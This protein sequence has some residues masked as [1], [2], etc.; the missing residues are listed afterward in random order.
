RVTMC[1]FLLPKA[2]PTHQWSCRC[3][4]HPCIPAKFVDDEVPTHQWSC[5][6]GSC[7]CHICNSTNKSMRGAKRRG[8]RKT[9]ASNDLLMKGLKRN[10]GIALAEQRQHRALVIGKNQLIVPLCRINLGSF[11]QRP[12][13]TRSSP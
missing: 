2:I 12:G 7:G 11:P 13:N 6:C 5:R 4:S 8:I 9:C 1:I 3:S 10:K